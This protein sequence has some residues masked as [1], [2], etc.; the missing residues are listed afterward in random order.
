MVTS[1]DGDGGGVSPSSL[2]SDSDR[3]RL[4]FASQKDVDDLATLL[5]ETASD[6]T[7]PSN[8][9]KVHA[10]AAKFERLLDEKYGRF[11]PIVDSH[12]QIEVVFRNLQRK[13][14]MGGFS[15]LRS[16]DSMPVSKTTAVIA[17]FMMHRNGVRFDAIVLAATFCLLGLQPWALV[18][19][20][21]LGR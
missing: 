3:P 21:A 17:L 9:W 12:P 7:A 19:L 11:R 20:V 6:F 18:T 14:A 2:A 13:Y 4:L 15:P 10:N 1:P 8:L 16:N 5:S